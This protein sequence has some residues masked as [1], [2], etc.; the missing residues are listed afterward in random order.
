M[1]MLYCNCANDGQFCVI[2]GWNNWNCANEL[3]VKFVNE[4]VTDVNHVAFTHVVCA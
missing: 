2:I 1:G 3:V 4:I